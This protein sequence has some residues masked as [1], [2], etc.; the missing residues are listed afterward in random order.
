[1]KDKYLVWLIDSK[2]KL[3]SLGINYNVED[4]LNDLMA[5]NARNFHKTPIRLHCTI[6]GYFDTTIGQVIKFMNNEESPCMKCRGKMINRK[7]STNEFIEILR[8]IY[9]DKNYSYNKLEY[10]DYKTKV[11]I[12]CPKHGDFLRL[13]QRLLEGRGC[14]YCQESLLERQLR[15][16]FDRHNIEYIYQ[17]RN[18]DILGKRSLDFFIP[19][20]SVGIECQ[21]KQHL[22]VDSIFNRSGKTLDEIYARDI[23]KKHMCENHN[24]RLLYFTNLKGYD[25]FDKLITSEDEL[26]KEIQNG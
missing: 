21:G 10:I 14:P 11:I 7:Y 25:Y 22:S 19:E 6:H 5:K 18:K 26:L 23:E 3:K 24:I 17:Y 2:Q 12:T 1:M 8:K 20:F 15:S 9:P 13:P 4:T 16:C